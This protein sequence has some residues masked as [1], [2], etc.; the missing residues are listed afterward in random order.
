MKYEILLLKAKIEIFWLKVNILT[1]F[2]NANIKN[3]FGLILTWIGLKFCA[4]SV[5]FLDDKALERLSKKIRET[6]SFGS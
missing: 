2:L 3:L 5:R 6:Y 1:F 4:A